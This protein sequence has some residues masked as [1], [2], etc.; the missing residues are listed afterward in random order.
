[1]KQRQVD[2]DR[3][4][5]DW[6]D[7]FIQ[8]LVASFSARRPTITLRLAV[9]GL[10]LFAAVHVFFAA[11]LPFYRDTIGSV[12]GVGTSR[13]ASD[14]LTALANGIIV[15]SVSYHLLLMLAYVLLSFV[16]RAA[17]RWTVLA[18]TLVLG[19]NFVV[20]LNGLRTPE[21]ANI[22]SVLQWITLTLS[23][24]I[25]LLL[26]STAFASA[27]ARGRVPNAKTHLSNERA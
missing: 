16:V 26:W 7:E 22:F 15:G 25:M 2:F 1:M 8:D 27:P 11:V 9:A 20:A 3:V 18:G 23:G 10:Y 6:A 13:V 19:A 14:E 12:I 4:L 17:R 21:I 5:I 24:A